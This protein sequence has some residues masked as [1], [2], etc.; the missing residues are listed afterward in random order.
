M[1]VSPGLA[2]HQK[3]P[4][5]HCTWGCSLRPGQVDHEKL[6]SSH[7]LAHCLPAAFLRHGHLQHCV[8]A[9]GHLIGSGGVLRAL[10]V[11]FH[12][13]LHDLNDAEEHTEVCSSARAIAWCS[14]QT[15][16]LAQ[17]TGK[18]V[19]LTLTG[20]LLLICPRSP[21]FGL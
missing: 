7:F 6:S 19:P 9:G 16:P 15:D 18:L 2:D 4:S 10:V 11:S 21:H 3:P 1:L 14:P 20:V 8:R 12:Q 5:S 17:G 13:Q